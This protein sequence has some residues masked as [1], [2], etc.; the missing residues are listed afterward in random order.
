MQPPEHHTG[1]DHFQ[2]LRESIRDCVVSA[3]AIDAARC[4]C[5]GGSG[6]VPISCIRTRSYTAL[7]EMQVSVW[8]SAC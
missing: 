6:V 3:A 8:I 4:V 7:R 2:L 5:C 1:A